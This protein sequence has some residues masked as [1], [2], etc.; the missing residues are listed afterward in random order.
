M[1][2]V[3]LKRVVEALEE[4]RLD[5]VTIEECLYYAAALSGQPVERLEARYAKMRGVNLSVDI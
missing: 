5:N 1:T 4:G 2:K 3:D